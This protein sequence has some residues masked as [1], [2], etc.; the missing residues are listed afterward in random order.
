MVVAVYLVRQARKP[1]RWVGR[2]FLWAMNNYHWP[3]T[4]WALSHVAGV[5]PC[6]GVEPGDTLMQRVDHRVR[7]GVEILD[8]VAFAI[9]RPV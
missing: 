8:T 5:A 9:G 7:H 1:N 4:R 6:V 2:P 3:V